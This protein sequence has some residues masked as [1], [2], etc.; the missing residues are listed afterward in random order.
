MR[1]VLPELAKVEEPW[2]QTV[3][4]TKGHGRD[5][6]LNVDEPNIYS[7]LGTT[8]IIPPKSHVPAC[9][10]AFPPYCSFCLKQ[11]S[12]ASPA[13]WVGQWPHF[14]QGKMTHLFPRSTSSLLIP[15]FMHSVT[16]LF[17]LYWIL[18]ACQPLWSTVRMQTWN[19]T[20]VTFRELRV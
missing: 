14:Q 19:V 6:R 2:N 18:N 1:P 7:P 10:Q 11:P 9:L 15:L 12:R 3:I 16:W 13:E 17:D 4:R 8:S 20:S 5:K